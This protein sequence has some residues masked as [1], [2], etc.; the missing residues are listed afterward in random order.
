MIICILRN[1]KFILCNSYELCT[2]PWL[3]D[4]EL[5][6]HAS[7]CVERVRVD[8]LGADLEQLSDEV[9][10]LGPLPEEG[11]VRVRR[12]GDAGP[13]YLGEEREN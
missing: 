6:G 11:A 1:D 13:V 12:R 5:V 8:P 9:A 3:A 10:H 4:L 7:V 2:V